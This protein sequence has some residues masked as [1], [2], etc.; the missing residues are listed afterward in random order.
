M[1]KFFRVEERKI[2][3]FKKYANILELVTTSMVTFFLAEHRAMSG[4][5]EP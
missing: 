4:M 3:C 5:G 1:R 2:V